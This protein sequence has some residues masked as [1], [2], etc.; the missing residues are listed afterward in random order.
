MEQVP[1]P[2]K[3]LLDH[4]PELT[5][6]IGP[7]AQDENF[8]D[9]CCDTVFLLGRIS[10]A[11]SRCAKLELLQ[12]LHKLYAELDDFLVDDDCLKS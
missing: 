1:E 11:E 12:I 10:T 7:C 6:L 9:L 4:R 3:A 2:V 8:Q 5:G